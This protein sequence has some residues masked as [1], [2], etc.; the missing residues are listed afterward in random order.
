[1]SGIVQTVVSNY[2]D[3]IRETKVDPMVDSWFLMGSPFPV[4]S[5][6]AVYLWF[7][8]K[9]GP[10]F[11]ASRKPFDLTPILI[12]YNGYQVLFS[13]WLSTMP[14]RVN[15]IP[16]L[17]KHGCQPSEQHN[18]FTIAVSNGAWWYFFSKVIEL[19]DTVFFV[20][21]KK[22]N[23]VSFLNVYHHTI[24]CLFSWC[25]LKYLPGEQG[26]VIGFLNSVVHV[27]LYTYYLIAALGPKYKKYLW[28]KK[29]VTKIQLA[30]FCIMLAYLGTLLVFDC[31]LPKSLT[32]FFVGNVVIFLYL[33]ADFY[34]KAYARRPKKAESVAAADADLAERTPPSAKSV[35][36]RDV[37][38]APAPTVSRR[39]A[40]ASH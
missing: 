21:R 35:Q 23:Q 27:V 7:V 28:W 37:S 40:Q 29:Y 5:I 12:L 14:L 10:A 30:Q 32:F 19:L 8:L 24:T 38:P 2:H 34:R 25:Y 17:L 31:K 36:F 3:I 20:L 33:F 9:A 18:P 39:H 1:M 11:M 6:L 22:Q 4:L 13:L 16:Y 15:A 26:V